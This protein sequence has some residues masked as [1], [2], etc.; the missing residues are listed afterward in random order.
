MSLSKFNYW[1]SRYFIY[2][3]RTFHIPQ[4]S[5]F[6]SSRVAKYAGSRDYSDIGE[7]YFV[8]NIEVSV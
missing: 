2:V 6:C 3:A 1:Q 5:T 4:K 8:D 7:T